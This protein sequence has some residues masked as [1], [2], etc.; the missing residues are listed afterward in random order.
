MRCG[1]LEA[2]GPCIDGCVPTRGRTDGERMR[3][4]SHLWDGLQSQVFRRLT[5]GITQA[6]APTPGA[7]ALPI[8][9]S[10]RQPAPVLR[11]IPAAGDAAGV[12]ALRLVGVNALRLMTGRGHRHCRYRVQADLPETPAAAEVLREREELSR[13]HDQTRSRVAL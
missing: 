4:W 6:A 9:G 5:G 11:V 1:R 7:Q 10:S 3:P 2:R 12:N 8:E 13:A